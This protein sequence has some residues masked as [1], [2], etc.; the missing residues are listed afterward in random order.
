M[1]PVAAQRPIH[2]VTIPSDLSALLHTGLWRS[3]GS[4][5]IKVATAGLTYLTYVVLSRTMTPRRIWPLRLRPGAGDRAGHRRR[6][7]PAHGHPAPLV[8]GNRGRP[9][10]RRDRRR[11]G[12]L[13]ADHGSPASPSPLL[14]CILIFWSPCS[15][16]PSTIP[17]T[18]S[19]APPSSCC[20]WR[21]P[22]TIP[23]PCAPR[24][25]CG[26]R[27]CRATSSGASPCPLPSSAALPSASCSAAPMRWCS[28]RRCWPACWPCSSGRPCGAAMCLRRRRGVTAP[29]GGSA[30]GSAAGC[31]WAPLIETAALNADV[32]LVGLMLD[33][34]SSGIYFNAFRTAGLMTLFT[35]AIELVIAPMVAQHFHAGDMR[36]AQAI[37]ALGAGAGFVFSLVDLRRLRRLGRLD[38]ELVR[39]RLCRRHAGAGAAVAR[40]AVR[41]R[42]RP[43]QDRHDD[44]RPRARLCRHLRHRSWRLGFL[45]QIARDPRLSALSA[46]PPPIWAPASSPSSPS[47]SGAASASGSIPACSASSPSRPATRRDLSNRTHEYGYA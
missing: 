37:T 41:R 34:E 26:P 35:F 1:V 6:R 2:A 20:P 43:L 8:A 22:N 13:D 25:R 15:S 47:P 16:S 18:T 30:A 42:D 12:R 19:M 38:P 21:W 44:D 11:A 28:R 14:L 45:V 31:C 46:P 23:P 40:P 3:V 4:L 17:P 10:G 5:G 7:R 9:Q 32:I 24:A 29:I 36:K 27:W 33:L 39:P